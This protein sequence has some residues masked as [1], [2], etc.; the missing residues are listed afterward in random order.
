[1]EGGRPAD[2]LDNFGMSNTPASPIVPPILADKEFMAPS[3]FE[4]ANLLREARRQKRLADAEV[5]EICVL[6]PDGDILRTLRRESRASLSPAWACY[7]TDLYEFDEGP[8]RFGII[9][10]A[11]GAS[12]AVLLAEQLFVSGCRFLVSLTSAGQIAD[13][14]SPPYFVVIDR[15]LRDEGTSYH[16]LPPAEFAEGDPTLVQA[17][18]DVLSRNGLRVYKGAAWT[19]DAPFRETV[20]AIEGCRARGI[21]A[22]EME[23]AALYAFA[24]ARQKPV[25]CLAHVT[26]QMAVSNGDFEKGEADGAY[27]SLAV[28]AGVA[29][30]W[31]M[32]DPSPEKR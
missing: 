18:M 5:P 24:H 7:H 22:V 2:W 4:P 21:L 14:G 31:R 19:T 9:G 8:E 11:V 13:Q 23:A 26:N 28:I 3:V 32:V 15:A 17:A 10:Y 1:M 6:D 20:V 16:Y 30:A 12:F 29:R 27:A 25:L